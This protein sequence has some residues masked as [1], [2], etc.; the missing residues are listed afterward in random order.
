MSPLQFEV[1]KAKW[2]DRL[3]GSHHV[4]IVVRK[5]GQDYRYEGDFLTDLFD[6][7]GY[8]EKRPERLFPDAQSPTQERLED[9]GFPRA[10]Q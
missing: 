7:Y 5:G 9:G 4:D 6:V 8:A 1:L 3:R 2:K 10:R